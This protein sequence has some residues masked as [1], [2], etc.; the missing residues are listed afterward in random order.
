MTAATALFGGGALTAHATDTAGATTGQ[1]TAGAHSSAVRGGTQ[2]APPLTPKQ[3]ADQ[4]EL[5]DLHAASAQA[6][7][8]GKPVTV[9]SQTTDHSTVVALPNGHFQSQDYVTPQRLK[10]S[11]AWTPI[12]STLTTAADGSFATKATTVAVTFSGGGTGPMAVEDDRAGHKLAVSMPVTLPKPTIFGSTALYPDVYPGVDLRLTATSVGFSDLLIVHD[13]TAAANPALKTLH[14]TTVGTGVTVSTGADGSIHAKDAAGHD[15]FASPRPEMWDSTGATPATVAAL[16]SHAAGS[17]KAPN[18]DDAASDPSVTGKH[19]AMPAKSSGD[20]VDMTPDQGLLK[21]PGTHYPVFLDPAVAVPQV[22]N[23]LEVYQAGDRGYWDGQGYV[24]A[25]PDVARVGH[26]ASSPAGPVRTL[27]DFWPAGVPNNALISNATVILSHDGGGNSCTPSDAFQLYRTNPIAPGQTWSSVAVTGGGFVNQPQPVSTA[28]CGNDGSLRLDDKQQLIDMQSRGNLEA[29]VGIR[30]V[31]E[32]QQ[33]VAFWMTGPAAA[34]VEVDFDTPPSFYGLAAENTN[35]CG[36]Y[37]NPTVLPATATTDYTIDNFVADDGSGHSL[38]VEDDVWDGANRIGTFTGNGNS[39]TVSVPMNLNLADGHEYYMTGRVWDNATNLWTDLPPNCWFTPDLSAPK[40]PS[41]TS[42]KDGSGNQLFPSMGT[43]KESIPTAGSPTGSGTSYAGAFTLGSS[44]TNPHVSLAKFEYALNIDASHAGPNGNCPAGAQCGELLAGSGNTAVL[45]L[46]SGSTHLGVNDLAVQAVDSVGNVSPWSHYMFYMSATFQKTVWGNVLGDGIPDIVT[47]APDPANP[48]VKALL[49]FP[50]NHDP[51]KST[52]PGWGGNWIVSA[53]AASAPNGRTWDGALIT[54]RGADRVVP[55]DDLFAWQD[56]ALYYYFNT[57]SGTANPTGSPVNAF[58]K[59]SKG[60]VTRPPAPVCSGTCAY[61]GPDWSGVKQIL[62]IGPIA[63]GAPGT[64]AGKTWLITV[65]ADGPNGTG[66]NV[67]A[68]PPAGIGQLGTPKLISSCQPGVGAGCPQNWN[69][70]KTTLVSPGNAAGHP[71]IGGSTFNGLPDLWVRDESNPGH[72]VTWQFANR[73]A[74]G[75]EDP[76]GL[77]DFTTATQI[78]TAGQLDSKTW[79]TLVS[80]GNIL[81]GDTSPSLWGVD[82]NGKLDL[83]HNVSATGAAMSPSQFIATSSTTT[84]W[85]GSYNMSTIDTAPLSVSSGP[86]TSNVSASGALRCLDVPNGSTAVGTVPQLWACNG[87]AAQV[88]TFTKDSTI[89]YAPAGSGP[90]AMC[91][92]SGGAGQGA[93]PYLAA[94]NASDSQIWRV[95]E[96]GTATGQM[97]LWNKASGLCLDDPNSATAPGTVYQLYQCNDTNAQ[98]WTPP[99]AAG[100][101]LS[102]EAETLTTSNTTG[103]MSVQTNGGGIAFSNGAQLFDSAA[104]VNAGFTVSYYVPVGGVFQVAPAMTKANDYGQVQVTVDGAATPLP[105][106]YD[107]YAPAVTAPVPFTFGTVALTAGMHT[108]TFTATGTNASSVNNRY[109]IGVDILNLNYTQVTSPAAA[110]SLS[111]S[112]VAAPSPV[113]ADASHSAP[114]G[115]P[116]AAY[117]FD[118]GDGTVLNGTAPTAS[119]GYVWTGASATY[120]IRATVTDTAG[121]SASTSQTVTVTAPTGPTALVD[122]AAK[123]PANVAVPISAASSTPGSSPIT[124]YTFDYGD[125]SPVATGSAAATSHTYTTANTYTIKV[126]ET[127]AENLT[128]TATTQIVVGG[129]PAAGY[130]QRVGSD[131]KATGIQPSMA[132]NLHPAKDTA[133][134]NA[135]VVSVMLTNELYGNVTASDSAGDQFTVVSDINNGTV[136]HRLVT[137]AAFRTRGLNLSDTITVNFGRSAEH[138]IAIDEYA[139]V[140]AVDQANAATGDAT[141]TFNSGFVQATRPG[142]M[143]IGTAG[144][145]KTAPPS[146]AA[147][148]TGL[149]QLQVPTGQQPDYLIAG[150][151]P[152]AAPGS[153][154]ATG[155]STGMWMANVASLVPNVVTGAITAAPSAGLAPLPVAFDASASSPGPNPITSYAFDFG[156]GNTQ[157]GSG[158]PKTSHTYANPGTFTAKVTVTDSAGATDTV[159]V[160]VVVSAAQKPL[161]DHG[162]VAYHVSPPTTSSTNPDITTSVGTHPLSAVPAG[163]TLVLSMMMTN[164]KGVNP[165]GSVTASDTQG[166][167]YVQVGT[168]ITDNAGDY[169]VAMA[170][171]NIKKG[172]GTGDTITVNWPSNKEHH[173]AV[174][175]FSGV[176]AVDQFSGYYASLAKTGGAFTSLPVTTGAANELLYGFAGIQGGSPPVWDTGWAPGNNALVTNRTDRL[177]TSARLVA[178]TGSYAAT[179][180]AYAAYMA[181]IVTL[182]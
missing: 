91:L 152:A 49:T 82:L 90:S 98:Q 10:L 67:W 96:S 41:V 46:N 151:Q 62:A 128:S 34:R 112:S 146:F 18:S 159:S 70:A 23:W 77:G 53:P 105:N 124:S 60:V 163:D 126:T 132:V 52:T 7:K 161:A 133:P 14:M 125:G 65:E 40:P 166:N 137:L 147:G 2:P 175:D 140:K 66:G 71:A 76:T 47:V 38:Q 43:G 5:N 111:S 8:T 24:S 173:L 44:V 164:S 172:L 178:A 153:F 119:H 118:F 103:T 1:S 169:V 162:M 69:W 72:D 99:S 12:D 31:D 157:A 61:Y 182:R 88:W 167:A 122:A 33:Q 48:N 113:T 79:P 100:K 107:G 121:K 106:T 55:W 28:N 139:G 9:D 59:T 35:L 68:Y 177:I 127:D 179:G 142:E 4:A 168:A 87:G 148:W 42:F 115:A 149:P 97:S 176:S 80:D 16:T 11:G 26:N 74:N 81:V 64:F 102:V 86:L 101:N 170:A 13:A 109:N 117:G 154:A 32:S 129:W 21:G 51:S 20:G 37:G 78:G 89:A 143:V 75:V 95:I 73:M 158:N 93:Q 22:R 150:Y 135:L 171:V 29:T 136:G 110:L 54:H 6:K 174:E 50:T 104:T 19:A 94:C 130:V 17:A 144:I 156:D 30:R 165:T 131:A 3:Q 141:T 160:Q 181:G 83:I 123:A 145:H 15:A 138:Q 57:L 108:F 84:N 27:I 45:N 56:G 180:T 36:G 25:N 92:D 155:S 39:G 114:G 116:I 58:A 134:G 85:P 63:G 120:T